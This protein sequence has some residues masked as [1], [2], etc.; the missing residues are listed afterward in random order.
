MAGMIHNT[1]TTKFGFTDRLRILIG[2]KFN[3][4][5]SIEVREESVNVVSTTAKTSITYPRWMYKLKK[6]LATI[7]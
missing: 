1:S 5:L 4:H 3:V 2:C 7:Y 6:I